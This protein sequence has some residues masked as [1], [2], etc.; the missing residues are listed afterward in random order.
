MPF[1][2]KTVA[3]A[4][5]NAELHEYY[6]EDMHDL[7]LPSNVTRTFSL[8]PDTY[9]GWRGLIRS[10]RKHLPL[11]YYELTTFAAALEMGC[12]F[13]LLAHGA[14]LRKNG[15]TAEQLEAIA[16]DFHRAGL[17]D[18]EVAMMD[19]AQKVIRDAGSTTRAD[20]D[21]LRSAGWTDEQI[22]AIMLSAAASS[23]LSKV[24]DALGAE[25][26]GIYKQLDEETH[27]ALRG[28]RPY[29]A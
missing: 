1:F 23:F 21:R 10:I 5:A 6:D 11:R 29:A 28:T 7:G 12:T 14:V 9:E 17:E 26:D 3:P 16:R 20:F 27:G 24:L 19:Y 22:L 13:C 4:D 8:F 25:A 18:K 15:F 2:I